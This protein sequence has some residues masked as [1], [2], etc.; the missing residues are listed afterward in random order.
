VKRCTLPL[1]GVKVVSMIVTD[2]AVIEVTPAGLVLQEIAADTT[3]DA[4][5]AATAADLKV[6]EKLGTFE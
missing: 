4:V 2:K 1:T 6:S 5:K 3:V